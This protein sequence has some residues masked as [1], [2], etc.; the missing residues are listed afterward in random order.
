[1][2]SPA[3]ARRLDLTAAAVFLVAVS[4]I[5]GALFAQHVLGFPPCYLCK[6]QR[7]PYVLAIG[8]GAFALGPWHALDHR[9]LALLLTGLVFLAGAGVALFHTGVEARWWTWASDCT[10]DFSQMNSVEELRK[11]LTQ[12]PVVR[13]DEPPFYVLGL[14][15]AGWNAVFSPL[16][17]ALAL[18]GAK[19]GRE[20]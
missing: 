5:A 13:C 11:K 3:F 4:A 14:S 19:S 6:W 2:A 20:P 9:R 18:W 15:M 1:M 16:F 12:A 8:L 10:G 7:V 17:A